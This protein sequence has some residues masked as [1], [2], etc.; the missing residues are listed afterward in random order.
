MTDRQRIAV[1][2]VAVLELLAQ[3]QA[4]QVAQRDRRAA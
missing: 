3:V 1:L 2:E 4:L